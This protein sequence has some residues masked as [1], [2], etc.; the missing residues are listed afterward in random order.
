MTCDDTTALKRLMAPKPWAKSLHAFHTL[1]A[2]FVAMTP[3]FMEPQLTFQLPDGRRVVFLCGLLMQPLVTVQ[4]TDPSSGKTFAVQTLNDQFPIS[5]V[6]LELGSVELSHQYK[7]GDPCSV[8]PY[9]KFR[10]P[11]LGLR[12]ASVLECVFS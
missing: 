8:R 11:T 9:L 12:A 6:T 2:A 1:R 10:H 7:E 5:A 4:Q 3:E